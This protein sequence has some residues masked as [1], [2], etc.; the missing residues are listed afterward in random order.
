MKKLEREDRKRK[1]EDELE[2]VGNVGDNGTKINGYE[3]NDEVLEVDGEEEYEQ[4]DAKVELDPE[5]VKKG[6]EDEVQFMVDKLGMF[7]FGTLED[8]RKRRGGRTPTTTR[9]LDGRKVG[10]DGK[11]FV[12]SRLVGRDF[13][14]KGGQ[15]AR[16][17]IRSDAAPGSEEG[18]VQDGGGTAGVETEEGIGGREDNVRGYS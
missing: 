5:E 3:V 10:D 16:R 18:L 12:R 14:A 17:I 1:A 13:K 15:G 4:E 8:A 7:E 6:R 9:W 11:E 2:D